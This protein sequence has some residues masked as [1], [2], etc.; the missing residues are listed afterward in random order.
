MKPEPKPLDAENEIQILAALSEL[1]RLLDLL[2]GRVEVESEVGKG[3]TFRVIIP[4]KY[5]A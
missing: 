1:R 4:T 2:H 3:S 5:S